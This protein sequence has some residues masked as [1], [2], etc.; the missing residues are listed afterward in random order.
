MCMPGCS[1]CA[2]CSTDGLMH[3]MSLH[4]LCVTVS[5]EAPVGAVLGPM[6][7]QW[8]QRRTGSAASATLHSVWLAN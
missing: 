4:T 3:H 5:E 8:L 7:V 6:A 2:L 1:C